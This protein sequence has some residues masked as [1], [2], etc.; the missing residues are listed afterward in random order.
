MYRRNGNVLNIKLIHKIALYGRISHY[1]IAIH[2][3]KN[4]DLVDFDNDDDWS[5]S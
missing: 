4:T 1:N 3:N 2:V 5:L